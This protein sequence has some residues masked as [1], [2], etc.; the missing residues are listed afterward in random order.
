MGNVVLIS[1]P[2]SGRP[3]GRQRAVARMM[4]LLERRGLRVVPRATTAPGEATRLSRDALESG[5]D[6][7]L[8]YGGDGTV[9]EVAQPLIG[10]STPLAVWPGGTANVLAREL[11]LPRD[12][13]RLADVIAARRTRRVSLGRAGDRYFLLMAGVGLD[14]ALVRAVDPALKRFLGQGAF[15]VAALQQ[16]VRWNPRPFVIDVG[17][18]RHEAVFALFA[19]A[20]SYASGMR[21]APDANMESDHLDLCL[22]N[23]RERAR[24]VRHL[25]AGF[26]GTLACLPGVRYLTIQR[27]TAEGD[28]VWVHVD[29]ELLAQLPITFECLP[30]TLSLVVP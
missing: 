28:G 10:S 22:V 15:W 13:E 6:L 9:N 17:G 3:G 25:R 8:V 27:A 21:I 20:A 5:A 16:L 23:W 1:N 2:G 19:N 4:E 30:A 29:G 11:G 14:A 26:T 12:L 24:I 7:I 18:Q